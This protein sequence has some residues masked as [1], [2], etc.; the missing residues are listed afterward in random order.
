MIDY[1]GKCVLIEKEVLV[2]GDLH[3]GY[4]GSLRESGF[5]FPKGTYK[6]VIKEFDL[7]F[8][9]I[10]NVK[11]V[12]LL[13][14]L[15]HEFGK[16]LREEWKEILDFIDYLKDKCN[17]IIVI[18]GNHDIIV[19][20]IL[21][22]KDI[23]VRDYFV[24]KKN[25]FLHGDKDFEEIYDRNIKNWFVGHGHPAVV[26]SDGVK[27][28]KYKCFL[29]GNF[30]DKE[31]VVLPSFFDVNEGSDPRDYDLGFVWDFNLEK[32]EVKIVGD[33]LNVLD[34]GLLENLC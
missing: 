19:E 3:L 8:E 28:E 11:K 6:K 2:V 25:C 10:S 21:K 1:I 18:K 15:K 12:V 30:K 9:K 7:I 33:K 27:K 5:I 17:K 16:I 22:K 26:L 13:G 20:P 31:V 32:F 34:F 4:E 29:V 24:W 23:I 14:D